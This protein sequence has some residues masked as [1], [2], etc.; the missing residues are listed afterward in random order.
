[1]IRGALRSSHNRESN[2]RAQ[3]LHSSVNHSGTPFLAAAL[4]P[5]RTP[6]SH[7]RKHVDLHF[8][9]HANQSTFGRTQEGANSRHGFPRKSHVF[10]DVNRPPHHVHSLTTVGVITGVIVFLTIGATAALALFCC[11][12]NFRLSVKDDEQ[13]EDNEDRQM[14]ELD[15]IFDDDDVIPLFLSSDS[16]HVT[17]TRLELR[18]IAAY[19]PEVTFNGVVQRQGF[20]SSAGQPPHP[21]AT[22]W[23]RSYCT[24]GSEVVTPEPINDSY[25]NSDPEVVTFEPPSLTSEKP[26]D[27]GMA[28]RASSEATG[29][30]ALANGCRDGYR[31]IETEEDGEEEEDEE[32][33]DAEAME[34][35]LEDNNSIEAE[36]ESAET[37]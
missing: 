34:T 32:E 6:S 30:P 12:R 28:W 17:R 3:G 5:H 29:Y 23:N 9:L 11:K 24:H 8:L 13:P 37:D 33:E 21:R 20:K 35:S 10:D 1:M 25:E 31:R 15:V 18:H 7:D 4:F 19:E 2:P 22:T 26:E 36:F 16:G 14:D 27:H